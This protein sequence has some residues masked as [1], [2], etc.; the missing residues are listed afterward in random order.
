MTAAVAFFCGPLL[1]AAA[2]APLTAAIIVAI[3]RVL[4]HRGRGQ[5]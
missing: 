2:L 5:R 3:D 1:I 4:T